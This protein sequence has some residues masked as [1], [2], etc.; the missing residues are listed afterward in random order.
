MSRVLLSFWVRIYDPHG[1]RSKDR[2]KEKN[3]ACEKDTRRPQCSR[4]LNWPW[5]S[6][7][8]FEPNMNVRPTRNSWWQTKP[9]IPIIIDYY[10][11][12]YNLKSR[13]IIFVFQALLVPSCLFTFRPFNPTWLL[14]SPWCLDWVSCGL[15]SPPLV[16]YLDSS[17]VLSWEW[18]SS[19]L[20]TCTLPLDVAR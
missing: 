13:F 3:R 10:A 17:L 5:K 2:R 4:K 1:W 20:E 19:L 7:T 15:A 8:I 16:L 11:V 18:P 9:L 12:Q 6:C 14:L